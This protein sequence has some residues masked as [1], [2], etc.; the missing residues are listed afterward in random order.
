M[1]L[2]NQQTFCLP[3]TRALHTKLAGEL[4]QIRG[5]DSLCLN[6]YRKASAS[7]WAYRQ[8]VEDRADGWSHREVADPGPRLE[9]A[10]S[11]FQRGASLGS[12]T[13]TLLKSATESAE[14]LASALSGGPLVGRTRLEQYRTVGYSLSANVADI[15]QAHSRITPERLESVRGLIEKAQKLDQAGNQE[16]A[17][18]VAH[19]AVMAISSLEFAHNDGICAHQ[20]GVDYHLDCADQYLTA[21]EGRRN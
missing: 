11:L 12:R 14:A 9:Q 16:A 19:Q 4:G 17:A 6:D 13:K 5:Q 15:N 20:R 21:A 2:T 10:L 7:L 8:D 3:S 1:Q 18:N